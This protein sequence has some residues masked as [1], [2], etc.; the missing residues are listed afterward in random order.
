MKATELDV[1]GP[2]PVKE[3]QIEADSVELGLK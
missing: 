3:G 2:K 1:I